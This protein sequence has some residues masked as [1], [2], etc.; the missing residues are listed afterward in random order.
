MISAR[1]RLG[2]I[3]LTGPRCDQ[4]TSS[5]GKSKWSLAFWRWTQARD[6]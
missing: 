5:Q 1:R 2:V 6:F 4:G 3:K